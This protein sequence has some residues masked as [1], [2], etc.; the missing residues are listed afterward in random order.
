VK[1]SFLLKTIAAAV[2]FAP[3][4]LVAQGRGRTSAVAEAHRPPAGMC[5]IWVDGVPADK[6]PAPTDCATALKNKP[7]NGRVVFG[8][9][10]SPAKAER[11]DPLRTERDTG[12][13]RPPVVRQK[14]D[15][16]FSVRPA[17]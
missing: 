13:A 3:V 14:R 8:E 5:R 2:A 15:T 11:K 16:V 10:K 12:K 7:T 17:R 4:A 1:I 6:Q 9:A